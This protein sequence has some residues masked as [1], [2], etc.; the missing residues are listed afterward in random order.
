MTS[1]Q[2]AGRRKSSTVPSSSSGRVGQP[3]RSPSSVS[4]FCP[5]MESE[6]HWSYRGI[7][8]TTCCCKWTALGEEVSTRRKNFCEGLRQQQHPA[9]K[10]EVFDNRAWKWTRRGNR[11]TWDAA[12]PCKASVF[13]GR[14]RCE[15]YTWNRDSIGS[16]LRVLKLQVK[17]ATT[18]QWRCQER[19]IRS[20]LLLPQDGSVVDG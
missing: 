16:F 4:L 3:F 8:V 17:K 18:T 20:T 12:F 7:A 11:S 19:R 1:V 2:T 6:C 15:I 5:R 9:S 14:Q 10:E 13:I